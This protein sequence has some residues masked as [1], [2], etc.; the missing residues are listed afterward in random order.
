[1]SDLERARVF[2]VD[3]AMSFAHQEN[4]GWGYTKTVFSKRKRPDKTNHVSL[5]PIFFHY[6]VKK[7]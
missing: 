2:L 4:R 3:N 6:I 7:Y 5:P 1:L